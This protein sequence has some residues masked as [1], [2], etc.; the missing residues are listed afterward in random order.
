M[1]GSVVCIDASLL[2]KL[3]IPEP[4]SEEVEALW[5]GW[6]RYSTQRV[7]PRLLFYEITSVLRKKVYRRLLT[8]DEAEMAL[9]RALAFRIELIDPAD[10]HKRAW[11][12][13]RRLNQPAAYDS[14]YLALA[15]LLECPFWT[16]DERLFNAVHEALTWVHWVGDS[17]H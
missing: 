16:G 5:Q 14:H 9:E 10:L 12:V 4:Y 8:D 1:N 15:E 2:I 17:R 3:V 11:A 7:A 6:A 13:A